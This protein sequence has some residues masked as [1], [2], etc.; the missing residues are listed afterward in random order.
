MEEITKLIQEY[1]NLNE[2][3]MQVKTSDK[4]S[5]DDKEQSENQLNKMKEKVLTQIN[6]FDKSINKEE[7]ES[8]ANM[9]LLKNLKI[10][11]LQ[12][13]VMLNDIK[14]KKLIFFKKTIEWIRDS[15]VK[16]GG[17]KT[18]NGNDINDIIDAD[19]ISQ[20]IM[21]NVAFNNN[22]II[23]YGD[24][25]MKILN[26]LQSIASVKE[27]NDKW[28]MLKEKNNSLPMYSFF[29]NMIF[30]VVKEIQNIHEQLQIIQTMSKF[31]INPF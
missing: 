26:E 21:M 13:Q 30:F 31:D 2:T 24:Y 20:K 8:Y 6:F 12:F 19:F 15:I 27:S 29:A 16:L 17:L 3:L 18:K 4:Y 1:Y 14:T 7:L 22:E 5:S 11:E 23:K 28:N 25:I 10:E 9:N